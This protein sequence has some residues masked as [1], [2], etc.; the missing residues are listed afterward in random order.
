M[1]QSFGPSYGYHAR[2][3]YYDAYDPLYTARPTIDYIPR[4]GAFVE[5]VGGKVTGW[6]LPK[7]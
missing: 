4:D 7:R 1:T 6:A 3:G 5:F 2:G